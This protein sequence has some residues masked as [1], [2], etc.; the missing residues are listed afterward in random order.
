MA[1]AYLEWLSDVFEEAQVPTGA[2]AMPY[3]DQVVRRIVQADS[4]TT[5]EQIL[6]ALRKNWLRHGRSGT[7]LLAGLIRG[8]DFSRRGSP[9]RPTEGVG[10][11][12]HEDY[13]REQNALPHHTRSRA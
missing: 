9:L 6:Q 7:Q 1:S 4:T 2:D 10:Y 8:E 12:T 13:V 5:D 3:L 11:Y